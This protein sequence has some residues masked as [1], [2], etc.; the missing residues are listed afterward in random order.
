MHMQ[1][2]VPPSPGA[3]QEQELEL[4]EEDES[5]LQHA[6][7]LISVI[8]KRSGSSPNAALTFHAL[9]GHTRRGASTHTLCIVLFIVLFIVCCV[10]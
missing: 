7:V 10:S 5:R 8:F 4:G 1:P 6:Q 2:P 3:A 9:L